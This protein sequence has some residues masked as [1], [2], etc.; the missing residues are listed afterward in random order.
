MSFIS[1]DPQNVPP[2][3]AYERHFPWLED[4]TDPTAVAW[5]DE[6]N[7]LTDGWFNATGL[8]QQA[9]SRMRAALEREQRTSPTVR[10][11]KTFDLRKAPGDEQYSLWVAEGGVERCLIDPGEL[12]AA[13]SVAITHF[14]PSPDGRLLAWATAVSGSDWMTLRI[15]DV[16]SG[17]DLSDELTW[18]KWAQSAWTPDSAGFYYLAFDPPAAG[19]EL[20]AQNSGQQIRYHRVGDAQSADVEV[21]RRPE[22]QWLVAEVPAD[23]SRLFVTAIDGTTPV[24]IAARDLRVP[25]SQ[26]VVLVDSTEEVSYVDAR[27]E[28]LYYVSYESSADGVLLALDLDPE[29]PGPARP[30]PVAPGYLDSYV[31]AVTER[32]VVTGYS[33]RS[34]Q[35]LAKTDIATGTVSAIEL[36]EH[37]TVS[38]LGTVPGTDRILVSYESYDE[39]TA[40]VDVDLTTGD[41]VELFRQSPT[42]PRQVR[43]FDAV[44]ADGVAVPV[45][46]VGSALDDA[47]APRPTLLVVYGGYGSD[48]LSYGLEDWHS[49]WIEA[50]GLIALAG[51]RGGSEYGDA[52]HR[53]GMRAGKQKSFDDLIAVAERLTAD[54][55]TTTPQLGINGMSNGGM[56]VA[57]ALTQRP[58]LFGAVVAEVGVMDMLQFHRFTVGAG[59]IREFGDPD[60][61]ADAEILREYSPLHAL[62]PGVAYPPTLVATGDHDDRVPPGV[63]SYRFAARMQQLAAESTLVLLRVQPGA[64]HGTG[65]ATSTRIEERG[66]II[67]FLS[68]QLGLSLT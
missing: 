60:A 66:D 20:L 42:R 33:S 65:K 62:Q 37:A 22:A 52:W 2:V 56:V 5:V 54:G 46:L 27:D 11:G 44:S 16:A 15:R 14:E 67:V 58:D 51:I 55:W 28:V 53:Q 10:G 34:P 64:G 13:G 47:T 48:F 41:R 25:D 18:I 4:H 40:I 17:Q 35:A 30:V 68:C 45:V 9:R 23:G 26:F 31:A 6:Q 57:A 1:T 39:G 19:A 50:G 8:R 3:E 7:A 24:H 43:T 61:P 12:D 29:E 49:V 59:W 38:Q 21:Y 63:H 32:F 36:P